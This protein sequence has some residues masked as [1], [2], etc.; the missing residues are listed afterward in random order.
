MRAIGHVRLMVVFAAVSFSGSAFGQQATREILSPLPP[1][2]IMEIESWFHDTGWSVT[3]EKLTFRTGRGIG[4][5]NV[6]MIA[7][8]QFQR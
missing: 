4:I 1:L 8:Q 2:K 3:P 5:V 6:M 7:V